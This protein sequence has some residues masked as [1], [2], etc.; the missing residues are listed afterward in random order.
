MGIHYR[1][2]SRDAPVKDIFSR[3][4]R[5]WGHED[6]WGTMTTQDKIIEDFAN[7]EYEHGFVTDIEQD[8]LPPG[9]DEDVIRHISSKKAEPEW[10]L[11]WRLKAYRHWPR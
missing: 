4:S 6:T 10:L 11:D 2:S 9:L 7:R 5:E 8:T 3:L 1:R